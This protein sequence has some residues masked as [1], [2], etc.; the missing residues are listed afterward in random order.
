M[1][2]CGQNLFQEDKSGEAKEV[3][4]ASLEIIEKLEK[5]EPKAT[6][7]CKNSVYVIDMLDIV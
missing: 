4:M 7:T 5:E 6:F 2:H 3:Y 1:I